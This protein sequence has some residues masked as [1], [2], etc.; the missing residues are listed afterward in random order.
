[1][2]CESYSPLS[3][4]TFSR[5]YLYLSVRRIF[6]LFHVMYS[7][8]LTMWYNTF[9]LSLYLIEKYL[10][11]KLAFCVRL[12]WKS[13]CLDDVSI[14]WLAFLF[15]LLVAEKSPSMHKSKFLSI[16]KNLSSNTFTLATYS[17][18]KSKENEKEKKNKKL[19]A[20]LQVFIFI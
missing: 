10:S 1:M 3:P 8:E 14:L 19:I 7:L 9:P 18:E 12:S 13:F 16:F 17:G 11:M 15:Y 2:K 4:F 20:S 5:I 6:F